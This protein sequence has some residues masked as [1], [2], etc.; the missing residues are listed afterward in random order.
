MSETLFPYL[1]Y[2]SETRKSD[3]LKL[4]FFENCFLLALLAMNMAASIAVLPPT[5][6]DVSE[7]KDMV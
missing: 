2:F 7:T 5:R 1:Y 3:T 6:S 4:E